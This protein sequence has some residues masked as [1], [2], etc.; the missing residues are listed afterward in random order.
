MNSPDNDDYWNEKISEK[1]SFEDEE[2]EINFSKITSESGGFQIGLTKSKLQNIASLDTI[3]PREILDKIFD[4]SKNLQTTRSKQKNIQKNQ[5][6]IKSTIEQIMNAQPYSLENYRSLEEKKTLLIEALDTDDGNTI[7]TVVIFLCNTLKRSIFQRFLR[8]N[9][10]A[11][12][13]YLNYL[14]SKQLIEDLVDTLQMLGRTR[15]AMMMQF[16][17]AC[18]NPQNF[19]QRINVCAN[20]ADDFYDKQIIMQFSTLVGKSNFNKENNTS[21]VVNLISQHC[22]DQQNINSCRI[23]ANE[24]NLSAKQLEATLLI[25]F[26]QLQNWIQIDDMFINKNWLGK[27]K[28]AITLPIGETVQLL[29]HNGAPTSS[30]TRYLK[31]M[32][33]SDN[34]LELAKK[35]HC[36]HLIIDDFAS[37]KDRRGLI[38]YKNNLQKQSESYFYADTILKSPNIKWKN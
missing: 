25:T 20:L 30:L 6:S 35:F 12:T 32:K 23:L 3:V 13:H 33:D 5:V 21:S 38:V 2:N 27:D 26:C 29:Y 24:F 1:F 18:R 14:F 22:K 9:P 16:K 8:E 19:Q 11:A 28:V 31:L 37:K 34:R 4:E 10:V 17:F 15:D 36:H 7:L